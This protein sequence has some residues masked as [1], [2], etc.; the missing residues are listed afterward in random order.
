MKFAFSGRVLT[1]LGVLCVFFACGNSHS[2]NA[3]ERVEILRQAPHDPTVYTQGLEWSD[4]ALW[5]SGGLYGESLIRIWNPGE[6]TELARMNLPGEVFGEGLT[7]SGD[8]VVQLTWKSGRVFYWNAADL[9]IKG[10]GVLQ[11]QGWGIARVE[12]EFW[13]SNGSSVI[14]RFRASDWKPAGS[15][16]IINN[17]VPQ[18]FL[19]EL[20]YARGK[21]W[22][23]VYQQDYIIRIDPQTGR[24]EAT[25]DCSVLRLEAEKAYQ[26]GMPRPEVLNGI[27]W[28]RQSD[29]FWLTGK[30]WP[31]I[32]EVEFIAQ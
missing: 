14:Q 10:E 5:E 11:G 21:L 30:H 18:N 17:G 26:P 7:L 6:E 1:C 22:A 29:T 4:S 13:V 32:F 9:R 20:E 16:Q 2:A 19:N 25:I 24:V 23:N 12:N 8:S 31:L 28:N 27:A 15:L 3:D